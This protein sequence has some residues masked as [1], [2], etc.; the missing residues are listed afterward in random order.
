MERRPKW[1]TDNRPN[2]A[3]IDCRDIPG[4]IRRIRRH[5]WRWFGIAMLLQ[6]DMGDVHELA[7]AE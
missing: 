6:M 5:G 3:L 7:E 1:E 2:L 4:T